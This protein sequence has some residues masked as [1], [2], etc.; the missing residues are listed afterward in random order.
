M[1]ASSPN[2]RTSSKGSS[3]KGT[4]DKG[5]PKENIKLIKILSILY[6][7]I[8]HNKW[9]PGY[10]FPICKKETQ[11]KTDKEILMD[12]LDELKIKYND[13]D[14]DLK[15]CD[16][17]NEKI[18]DYNLTDII[19]TKISKLFTSVF[20][21]I[22]STLYLQHTINLFHTI[23]SIPI[24]RVLMFKKNIKLEDVRYICEEYSFKEADMLELLSNMLI[25]IKKV[26]LN[27]EKALKVKKNGFNIVKLGY[28]LKPDFWYNSTFDERQKIIVLELINKL[29]QIIDEGQVLCKELINDPNTKIQIKNKM[30]IEDIDVKASYISLIGLL[31]VPI[32]SF[33]LSK[34]IIFI[35]HFLNNKYNIDKDIL[36]IF[37]YMYMNN[38]YDKFGAIDPT[39][40]YCTK[41]YDR[42]EENIRN[43][44]RSCE[45]GKKP[46][47]YFKNKSFPNKQICIEQCYF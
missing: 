42:G 13:N 29:Q 16:L 6:G 41:P 1:S 26:I 45:Q 2:K 22:N 10:V 8:Q 40:Y 31:A 44:V 36:D 34:S 23:Y 27:L 4:P 3:V 43:R 7:D 9:L 32:S 47:K 30:E 15:L 37:N 39:R 35:V 46:H 17:I 18:G 5:T 12:I 21:N 28:G 25:V 14:A 24:F 38:N 20:K 33:I 19:S 11:S